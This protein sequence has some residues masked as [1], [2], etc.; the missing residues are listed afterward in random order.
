MTAKIIEGKDL[1]APRNIRIRLEEAT[2]LNTPLVLFIDPTNLCNIRCQ[3]CPTGDKRL[4]KSVGRPNGVMDFGLFKK[5][6]NDI[7]EFDFKIKLINFYKDGEP[8][9]NKNFPE[10]AHHLISANVAE[11]VWLKTNGLLLNPDLNKRLIASGLNSINI[12]I[13][14]ISSEGYKKV[15]LSNIN[16]DNLLK[17]IRD[18]YNRR[19]DCKIYVKIANTGLTESDIQKFQ[20]DF[21][22][23]ADAIYIEQLHGW[24]MSDV[25]DFTLGTNPTT[26][27]GLPLTEKIACP[28][29]FYEMAINW[30]GTVSLCNEDWAHKTLIGD[31]RVNS[32][33]QIWN[34][35]PLYNMRKMMLEG[36]RHENPM[37]KNCYN[38]KTAPDNIDPFRESMLLK[39][40]QTHSDRLGQTPESV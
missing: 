20:T 25:K 22:D 18:L 23:I 28:W 8:L 7:R 35:T 6:V 21:S 5:I 40:S 29:P 12:S 4:L 2:P 15:A 27:D 26:F 32:L 13:Q 16:Y 19:D 30:D 31:V 11:R 14:H 24:A 34:G 37:C 38:I 9:V 33:K 1:R 17:N 3:Y 10:M 36:R 39:I